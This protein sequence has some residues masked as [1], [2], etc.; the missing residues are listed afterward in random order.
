ML[1]LIRWLC[2][3]PADLDLQCFLKR[4]NLGSIGQGFSVVFSPCIPASSL[5]VPVIVYTCFLLFYE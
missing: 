1:I 2:E 4:I 3:K 5:Y